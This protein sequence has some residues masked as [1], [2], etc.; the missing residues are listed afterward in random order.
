MKLVI[1][2]AGGG[3]GV[4]VVRLALEQGH[5][6]RAVV[7]SP[8]RLAAID[9]NLELSMGDAV[10]PTT[11]R[12]AVS[13]ADAVVSLIGLNKPP[14][15][16]RTVS[17]STGN[18][19]AAMQAHGVRRF[20]SLSMFGLGDSLAQARWLFK[21]VVR[22]L[23]LRNI[24]EDRARQEALVQASELDWTL[25]RP[26]HLV[27]RPPSGNVSVLIKKAK[28]YDT[29]SRADVARSVVNLVADP[30]THRKAVVLGAA[31]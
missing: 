31:R 28:L 19:L 23:F 30:T 20:V 10:E 16:D 11:A 2:G 7:R 27:D 4:H 13:G 25:V 6:V 15:G 9:S 26:T 12:D 22:P 5:R 29:V 24:L 1:F 21:W 14:R 3:T 18:I 17:T 8:G